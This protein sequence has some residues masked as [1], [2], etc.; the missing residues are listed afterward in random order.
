MAY[1]IVKD[2]RLN[3]ERLVEVICNDAIYGE[4][5]IKITGLLLLDSLVQ[6]GNHH[7]ENFIVMT[8]MRSTKLFHII[9]SLKATDSLL[10]AS[11]ENVNV[12]NFLYELTAFKATAYFLIRIAE[13]RE[14]AV[15]LIESKVFDIL[16][17]LNFLKIDPDLGLELV[18]DETSN[19]TSSLLRVN[20]TFDEP[21]ILGKEATSVSIFELIIP[22]FQL[23]LAIV[24]S[25]G[26]FNDA[27]RLA[28]TSLL[29]QYQKLIIGT[30]K[31]YAL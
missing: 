3:N 30:F 29:K 13:T 27:V 25:S 7:Q 19:N 9:R 4:G 10:N 5:A 8:L 14:G 15:A 16:A 31:R 17:E 20:I 12:E 11:T 18:F 28:T 26:R 21:L 23:M 24:I 6:L 22:I 1:A 2:L